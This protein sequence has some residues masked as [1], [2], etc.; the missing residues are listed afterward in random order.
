M[1]ISSARHRVR[2]AGRLRRRR[3]LQ[4]STAATEPSVPTPYP[5]VPGVPPDP[6]PVPD[7]VPGLR[8]RLAVRNRRRRGLLT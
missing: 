5:V 1:T 6:L 2:E 4:A 8:Y 3:L 7:G